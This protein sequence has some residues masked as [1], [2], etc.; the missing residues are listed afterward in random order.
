MSNGE[1]LFSTGL[2]INQAFSLCWTEPVTMVFPE[3]LSLILTS[4]V[5]VHSLY[6]STVKGYYN[7]LLIVLRALSFQLASW[8]ETGLRGSCTY[9]GT[10]IVRQFCFI[11]LFD[12][13]HVGSELWRS[14]GHWLSFSEEYKLLAKRL[15]DIVEAWLCCS[16]FILLSFLSP[17]SQVFTGLLL[18]LA[19][20]KFD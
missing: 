19:I 1:I 11:K 12:M 8:L 18:K 15:R 13:F 14:V 6:S 17:F 9:M 10:I 5:M 4:N 3:F 20:S 7:C 2:H 16:W